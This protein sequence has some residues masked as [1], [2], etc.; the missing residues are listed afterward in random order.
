MTRRPTPFK[1]L[2]AAVLLIDLAAVDVHEMAIRPASCHG[3]MGPVP[4]GAVAR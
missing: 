3:A 2:L 1:L 4:H